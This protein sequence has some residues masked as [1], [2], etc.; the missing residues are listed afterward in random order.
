ML[1][2]GSDRDGLGVIPLFGNNDGHKS[3]PAP[4]GR[5]PPSPLMAACAHLLVYLYTPVSPLYFSAFLL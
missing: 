3:A 4:F 1:E 2:L 5:R